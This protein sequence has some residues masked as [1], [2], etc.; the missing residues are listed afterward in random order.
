VTASPTGDN[1]ITI[2]WQ[3]NSTGE[4]SYKILRWNSST[5]KWDVIATL[6]ANS[7]AYADNPQTCNQRYYYHVQ[8]SHSSSSK[9]G[10]LVY[11]TN[12][13][14]TIADPTNLVATGS[15]GRISLS[16]RDRSDNEDGFLIARWDTGSGKWSY[17]GYV[18]LNSTSWTDTSVNSNYYYYYLVIGYRKSGS[19]YSYSNW[20]NMTPGKRPQLSQSVELSAPNSATVKS[21]SKNSVTLNWSNTNSG[22]VSS[23]NAGNFVVERWNSTA[24]EW[25]KLGQVGASATSCVDKALT[26]DTSY[27]YMVYAANE[28]DNSNYSNMV[29]AKTS[30]CDAPDE[31]ESQIAVCSGSGGSNTYLPVIIKNGN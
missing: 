1:K 30:S 21:T 10:N 12:S 7:T 2:R 9:V 5:S 19:S 24:G 3:D 4:E 11:A 23:R 18:T 15:T 20:S 26:C 25:E 17:P 16:W 6:A 22:R 13:C 28:Y 31:P 14:G 27:Y 29:E 8:A